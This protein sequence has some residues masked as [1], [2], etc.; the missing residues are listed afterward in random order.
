MGARK[1]V[2]FEIGPIGCIP[3]STRQFKHNG[4]CV[5]DFNLLAHLFNDELAL[6]LQNLT[7]TLPGSTFVL[8]HG[9]WLGYDA[10]LYPSKYGIFLFLFKL[11]L[12]IIEVINTN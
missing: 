8:G 11:N 3:S 5:E 1:V 6:M 2:M 4:Q 12:L 10:V 9:H 7:A